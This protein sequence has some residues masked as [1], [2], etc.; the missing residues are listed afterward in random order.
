MFRKKISPRSNKDLRYDHIH[1]K[2]A[3]WVTSASHV[4][5][6]WCEIV[7]KDKNKPEQYNGE[8]FDII[9]KMSDNERAKSPLPWAMSFEMLAECVTNQLINGTMPY[10]FIGRN[11]KYGPPYPPGAEIDAVHKQLLGVRIARNLPF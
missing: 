3:L 2:P 5:V 11:G 10:N 1:V 4:G 9:N 8:L 6:H 7:C